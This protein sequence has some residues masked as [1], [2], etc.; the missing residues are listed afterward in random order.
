MYYVICLNHQ[1]YENFLRKNRVD[2][3]DCVYVDGADRLRG[4]DK[5]N[6]ILTG[7]W[8]KRP[9]IRQIL[10]Q[11]QVAGANRDKIITALDYYYSEPA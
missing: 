11:L 4:I 6:G 5:P 2:T 10:L 1:E 8:S 3:R 7:R 9:D